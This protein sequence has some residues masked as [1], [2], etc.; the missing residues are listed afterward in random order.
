[1]FP[2]NI[3]RITSL[4]PFNMYLTIHIVLDLLLFTSLLISLNF[5]FFYHFLLS[6]LLLIPLTPLFYFDFATAACR[7]V[8]VQLLFGILKLFW[9]WVP[10]ARLSIYIFCCWINQFLVLIWVSHGVSFTVYISYTRGDETYFWWKC[11][12]SDNFFND[13]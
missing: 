6:L 7:L 5:G 1:M 8:I 13:F 11:S 12:P 3:K 2:V 9:C 4:T 10:V